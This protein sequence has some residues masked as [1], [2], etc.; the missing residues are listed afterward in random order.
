MLGV[1]RLRGEQAVPAPERA[2]GMRR[3]LAGL[4]CVAMVLQPL[5][6]LAHHTNN[7]NEIPTP[8]GVRSSPNS[9]D[10]NIRTSKNTRPR[11]TR[12]IVA[13]IAGLAAFCERAPREVY[14]ID[15]LG[16]QLEEIAASMATSG[17][18]AEAQQIIA[19]A[20][21]DLRALARANR[22]RGVR[23]RR[24]RGRINR[25]RVES[26]PLIAV[27]EDRLPQVKAQAAVILDQAQIKLLRSATGSER[28]Q[29]AYAEMAQVMGSNK[30]LLRSG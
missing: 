25:N 1:F 28:R 24:V 18:Y 15:C 4:L 13:A 12:Q 22:A 30:T 29:V 21:R 8:P 10:Y 27:Q 19:G 9:N 3:M 16:E 17:D 2:G 11:T 7:P 20:A 5:D 26:K 14:Q 23:K 6:A